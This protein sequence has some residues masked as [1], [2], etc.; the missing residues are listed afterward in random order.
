MRDPR[1]A[2]A[3]D[4]AQRPGEPALAADHLAAVLGRDVEL[5]HGRVLTLDLLDAHGVGIVDEL[6]REPGEQLGH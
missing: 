6:L 1:G 3:H 2:R 5:E 4:R